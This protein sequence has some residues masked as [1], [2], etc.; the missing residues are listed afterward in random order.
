MF[1]A[2][3]LAV[4]YDLS[5]VK[6][7]KA[8]DDRA[9]FRR[10]CG[11]SASEPTPERTAFVRFRKTLVDPKLDKLLFE[12][13]TGQL[14]AKAIR[15]KIGTLVD[16]T[17]VTSASKDDGEAHWVKHKGKPAVHGFKAHVGADADTTLAEE[18]AVTPANI[19]DG[20]AGPAALPDKPGEVFADSAYRGKPFRRCVRAGGGKPQI[21]A[22][23]M[24]GSDEAETLA[25]L[26]AWSQPIHRIRGRIE[27]IF[28]TWK[29][30][31]ELRRIRRRGL[32]KA[33]TQFRL[34]AITYNLRRALTIIADA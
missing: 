20:K 33:A 10:F 29:R 12:A 23:G 32:A 14:K 13:V 24:W 17:I 16:A 31:Y 11:F 4:W 26:A 18:I 9:S 28:G 3:L 27:K 7:A 21:V 30:S 19:N 6:L 1:K 25:R 8:L 2:T 34:T 5:D 22:T 15:I